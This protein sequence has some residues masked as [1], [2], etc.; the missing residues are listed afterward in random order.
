MVNVTNRANVYVRLRTSEFSFAIS[1]SSTNSDYFLLMTA[2]ATF[3]GAS[4]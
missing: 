3:F 2:S 1:V 4:A